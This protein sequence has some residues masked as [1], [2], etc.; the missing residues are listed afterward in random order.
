MM[1]G[2][3]LVRRRWVQFARRPVFMIW[4]IQMPA[5]NEATVH[6]KEYDRYRESP[7]GGVSWCQAAERSRRIFEE[8]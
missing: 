2:D 3:V 5:G 4:S 6:G 8:T 7:A 1:S